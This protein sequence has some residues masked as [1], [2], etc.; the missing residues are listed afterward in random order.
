MIL[1]ARLVNVQFDVQC[2]W[3][4]KEPVYRVYIDDELLTERTFIWPGFRNYVREMALVNL[5]PGKHV[6][7]I[8]NLTPDAGTFVIDNVTV[9]DQ[10]SQLEFII[11]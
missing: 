5:L 8:E 6:I 9:D 2:H 1:P 4:D 11:D 7:R 3:G 10:E